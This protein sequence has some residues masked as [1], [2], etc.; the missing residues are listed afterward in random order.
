MNSRL[1]VGDLSTARARSGFATSV[2]FDAQK[3][4]FSLW[5]AKLDLL[6]CSAHTL[7]E[8]V[9]TATSPSIS[10]PSLT[11]DELEEALQQ[12]SNATKALLGRLTSFHPSE[13]SSEKVEELTESCRSL[14]DQVRQ[15]M[16]L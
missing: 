16:I 8:S 5:F 15:F 6:F 1:I 7:I 10:D 9:S 11:A 4:P 13:S 2:H 12:R 14:L 3:W